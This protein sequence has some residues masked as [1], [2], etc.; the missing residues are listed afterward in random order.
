ML[1]FH[2]LCVLVDVILIEFENLPNHWRQRP[3]EMAH[4]V[5]NAKSGRGMAIKQGR[6]NVSPCGGH[7][8]DHRK[9]FALQKPQI[10]LM[11]PLERRFV[12]GSVNFC[13]LL[14]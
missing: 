6:V 1:P 2:Q 9:C 13:S 12:L 7:A 10:C 8:Q 3:D 14:C 11:R 5:L 4:L